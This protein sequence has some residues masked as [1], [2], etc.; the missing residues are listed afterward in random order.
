MSLTNE[1]AE[2]LADY[3]G[4]DAD[5]AEQL[6]KMSAEK[7]AEIINADGYDFTAEELKEFSNTVQK[8]AV[9]KNNGS[10]LSDEELDNVS[11]GGIGVWILRILP[12]IIG[13]EWGRD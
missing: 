12:F 13:V 1:R 3:L 7:A 8:I 5:R 10:E 9:L 11:G 4:A 6:G 2:M